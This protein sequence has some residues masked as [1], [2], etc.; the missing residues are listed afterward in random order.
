[1]V[2]FTSHYWLSNLQINHQTYLSWGDDRANTRK[3]GQTL[4]NSSWET[5]KK[6]TKNI[7]KLKNTRLL[8]V[9]LF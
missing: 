5:Y 6:H 4:S 1:M 9:L 3:L 2:W 7:I 8:P